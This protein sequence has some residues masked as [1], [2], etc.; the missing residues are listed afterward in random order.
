MAPLWFIVCRQAMRPVNVLGYIQFM[1][2]GYVRTVLFCTQTVYKS[3]KYVELRTIQVLASTSPRLLLYPDGPP[4]QYL[5]QPTYN[6]FDQLPLDSIISVNFLGNSVTSLHFCVCTPLLK[7][8]NSLHYIQPG[9]CIAKQVRIM[10]YILA[11]TCPFAF[12]HFLHMYCV[13]KKCLLSHLYLPRHELL[14][15]HRHDDKS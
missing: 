5:R 3:S 10:L 11:N 8:S 9:I 7:P 1:I 4:T 15:Q 12:H 13:L 6:I 2:F 14:R